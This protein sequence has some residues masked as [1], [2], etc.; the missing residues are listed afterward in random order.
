[1]AVMARPMP[2][3]GS[4]V[5]CP[6]FDGS[7]KSYT[8]ESPAV[9]RAVSCEYDP[10]RQVEFRLNIFSR[11]GHP[12]DK[13]ELIIMGGTFL[14]SPPEYQFNF[15]KSCYDALNGHPSQS[16]EQAKDANETA[17]YRCV[18]L[19]IETR[20]DWC[21]EDDVRRM[22]EFGTTRVELGV[23]TLDDDIYRLVG[24]GHVSADVAE[25]TALLKRHGLKVYYH[26]MP[27]LPGSTPLHDLEL[28]RLLFDDDKYKPDGIK[29]YPTLVV[30][31]TELERWYREGRYAPYS[32]EEMV[33]LIADIKNAIPG[34]V[35][36]PR[37]MRDIPTRFIVAGCRDL[38][39]RSGV[40]EVMKAKGM[41][42]R[43]TRCREYGH[44]RRDGWKTGEPGLHRLDYDASGGTEIFLSFEDDAGTLFGLLRLR[45]GQ[46][47]IYPATVRE[48]HIFGS[49]VPIGEQDDLAAQ[50]K[51]LGSALM[52]EAERIARDEFAADSIAVISGVGA[53]DYFRHGF[54]YKP[55]GPYMCK[56]LRSGI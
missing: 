9:L 29:I 34:Y 11:M 18:G 36:I 23:Q 42:C 35:R 4:C 8:P 32:T 51:G 56:K 47:D 30:A 46:G 13:V 43:C 24:R 53:R 37:V 44:R 10:A 7:P 54:G 52:K 22:L 31:G 45:I 16:L 39:L 3:P 15:I 38:S 48:I 40:K 14:S 26:W 55:E 17:R 5:F 2:C 25:A 49:E 28:A 19:C 6:S 33:G 50:H 41:Q 21:S 27:G 12:I 20:P 1:M